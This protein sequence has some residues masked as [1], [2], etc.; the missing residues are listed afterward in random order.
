MCPVAEVESWLS[1]ASIRGCPVSEVIVCYVLE[2][3]LADGCPVSKVANALMAGRDLPSDLTPVNGPE[4]F[5]VSVGRL[6]WP[7]F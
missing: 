5:R 6:I 7:E 3:S 2:V 1:V 4:V